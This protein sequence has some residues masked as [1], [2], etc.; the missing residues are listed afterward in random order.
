MTL[1]I[2][3]ADILIVDD[4]VI[5]SQGLVSLLEQYPDYVNNVKVAHDFETALKTLALATIN[6]LILDL[7]FESE[8]Y[9]GFIIA[10]KVKNLYP[11]IKIIILTQ[12][13]KIDNYE[14]LFN[15]IDVDGYLDKQLGIEETL[16]ALTAVINNKKYIDKNIKAMLE[17]GRWLNISRRE[18]DVINLLAIG[19]TQKEIANK[20]NISNRT[21]E[22]HIKNLSNKME[23]KNTTHLVSIYTRYKNGNRENLH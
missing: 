8:D 11:E 14:V 23:A 7:N 15:Q 18:K 6:V 3:K 21:V 4:S 13:A 12:E 2:T 10:K 19:L 5:F 17:I 22:T 1:K 20:L 9:N 16:G